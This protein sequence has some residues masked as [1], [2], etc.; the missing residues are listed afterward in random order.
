MINPLHVATVGGH[1]LRF[2]KTPLNDGRPDFPWLAIE[3]LGRCVG[4]DRAGRRFFLRSLRSSEWRAI[5]RTVA[6]TDR[7][8]HSRAAFRGARL[9]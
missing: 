9:D 5:P 8:A 1:P 6:T 4:F 2:F 3:D 7:R